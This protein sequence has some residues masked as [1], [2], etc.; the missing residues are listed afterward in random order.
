MDV[1]TSTWADIVRLRQGMD[2]LVATIPVASFF[3]S[4][5]SA[6]T[7]MIKADSTSVVKGESSKTDYKIVPSVSYWMVTNDH[8]VDM[9][10]LFKGMQVNQFG[11]VLKLQLQPYQEQS[12]EQLCNAVFLCVKDNLEGCVRQ[13]VDTSTLKYHASDEEV[14]REPIVKIVVK[15]SDM[16]SLVGNLVSALDSVQFSVSLNVPE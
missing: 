15:D 5:I 13:L 11:A 3:I 7:T 14:S 16:N 10:D 8:E 9:R 12:E 2:D 1:L 6:S 4:A